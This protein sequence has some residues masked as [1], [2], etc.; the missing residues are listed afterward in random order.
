MKPL[1]YFIGVRLIH[2]HVSFHEAGHTRL[3]LL[4]VAT[5]T[6]QVKQ[7]AY[8]KITPQHHTVHIFKV[9]VAGV[10]GYALILVQDIIHRKFQF[11]ILFLKAVWQWRHSIKEYSG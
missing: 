2:S 6:V 7:E 1:F 4:V 10:P 11:T 8:H 3:L 5:H 9:V